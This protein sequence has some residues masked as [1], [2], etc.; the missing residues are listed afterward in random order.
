MQEICKTVTHLPSNGVLFGKDRAAESGIRGEVFVYYSG[1]ADESGLK[2]GA[3]TLGWSE[4]RNAVNGLD[5]DVRVAVLDACGSGAIT[6]ALMTQ[7]ERQRRLLE[8]GRAADEP[9]VSTTLR[10][11]KKSD[12]LTASP[13]LQ[14]LTQRTENAWPLSK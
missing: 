1:H 11:S 8:D 13:P 6:R 2:L 4:F 9:T 7:R 5:A 12:H 10:W 14:F 3:E